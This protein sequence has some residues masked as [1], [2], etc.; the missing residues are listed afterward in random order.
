M[1]RYRRAGRRVNTEATV[2]FLPSSEPTPE[3]VAPAPEPEPE[4]EPAPDYTD[5]RK[6]DLVSLAEERGLDTEG[7]KADLIERLSDG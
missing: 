7:T 6:A 3:P 1:A 2:R 4:P 5:W